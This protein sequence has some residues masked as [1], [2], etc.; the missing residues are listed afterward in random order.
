MM[1]TK[2][3]IYYLQEHKILDKG[4][5]YNL[6]HARDLEAEKQVVTLQSGFVV[7]EY[8]DLFPG[9]PLIIGIDFG[10]DVDPDIQHTSIPP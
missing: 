7:I 3:F 9:Q 5:L 8:P 1:P 4:C 2:W 10:I 6:V